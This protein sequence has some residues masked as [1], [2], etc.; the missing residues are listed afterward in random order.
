MNGTLRKEPGHASSAK[1]VAFILG[2]IMWCLETLK[3][4]NEAREIK[5]RQEAEED[6][7]VQPVPACDEPVLIDS[8]SVPLTLV[9]I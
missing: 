5:L 6:R 1:A 7:E 8:T 4:L 9:T 3:H 2:G